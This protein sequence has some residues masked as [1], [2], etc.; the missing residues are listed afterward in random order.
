MRQFCGTKK[1]N[2][3]EV[4]VGRVT[5]IVGKRVVGRRLIAASD[6][7]IVVVYRAKIARVEAWGRG[8]N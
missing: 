2:E 5:L 8:R 3:P 1:R 7:R 4:G 6:D